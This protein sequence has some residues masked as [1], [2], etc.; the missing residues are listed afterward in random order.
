MHGALYVVADLDE[1]LA[2]PEGYLAKNPLTIKDDLLKFNRPRKEW[3]FEELVGS[4]ESLKEGRS[5]ANGK[6][7]FQAASCAACHKVNGIGNEIG[8]DLTKL[9]PKYKPADVL[10]SLLEPSEKIDEKY[11]SWVIQLSS[12]KTV[13]GMILEEKD[14]VIK[15][16]EN[17]L[18]A[19]KPVEIKLTEIEERTKSATSIMPKGLLDKLTHDEILDLM[20]YLL[21]RGD[22]KHALYSGH[23][24]HGH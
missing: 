16:V 22:A 4:V 13:T 21:S 18:A 15:V 1:Y 8:P 5:F 19:A 12:G 20:A 3:K 2:D 11:R 23:E 10:K 7:L 6:Q 14:G 17:P 24:H 9:D